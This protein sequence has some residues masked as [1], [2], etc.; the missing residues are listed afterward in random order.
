MAN[1]IYAGCDILENIE[2]SIETKFVLVH[3]SSKALVSQFF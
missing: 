2:N 1:V 3:F